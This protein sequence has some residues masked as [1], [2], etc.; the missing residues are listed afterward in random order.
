MVKRLRVSQKYVRALCLDCGTGVIGPDGPPYS[1]LGALIGDVLTKRLDGMGED[2]RAAVLDAE[3]R[4]TLARL[5][6]SLIHI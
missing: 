3:I 4:A 2:E 6:L 5:E 1:R